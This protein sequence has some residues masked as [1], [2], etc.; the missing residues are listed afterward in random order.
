MYQLIIIYIKH[1]RKI[2]KIK[3]GKTITIKSLYK[4]VKSNA[5]GF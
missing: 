3:E 4:K 2:F 1:R 5:F